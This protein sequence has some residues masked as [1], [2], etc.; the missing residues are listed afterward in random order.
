MDDD[1][2][3]PPSQIPHP[4]TEVP[5][6]Y[7]DPLNIHPLQAVESS[8]NTS[9]ANPSLYTH[10]DQTIPRSTLAELP[11][12]DLD[13]TRALVGPG[14]EVLPPPVGSDVSSPLPPRLGLPRLSFTHLPSWA[15][16]SRV[17]KTMTLKQFKG[18]L[19]HNIPKVVRIFVIDDD[20]TDYFGDGGE[21][22][23]GFRRIKKKHVS[24]VRL[25]KEEI[26]DSI[27]IQDLSMDD[28]ND[29]SP[30]QIPH[31]S[32][33][34]PTLYEDHLNIHPLQAVEPSTNASFSNLFLYTH[35]DQ[36]IPRSTLAEFPERDL[37]LTRALVSPGVE[38]SVF[39]STLLFYKSPAITKST[40][41]IWSPTPTTCSFLLGYITKYKCIIRKDMDENGNGNP[42]KYRVEKTMSLKQFKGGLCLNMPKVVCHGFFRR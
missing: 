32:T 24:E 28:D 23:G 18:G 19:C 11:G 9:F 27:N 30:S 16:V 15:R 12:R 5:T 4:S 17:D 33:E 40:W 3:S 20:A 26:L 13:L 21:F 29:S 38:A 1:D 6:L 25:E 41:D 8:T 10:L 42:V 22:R 2:G 39:P 34:V 37:D 7:E 31:T 35:L 14:V 36:T